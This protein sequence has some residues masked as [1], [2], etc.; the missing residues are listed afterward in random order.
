MIF[1]DLQSH[2]ST[3]PLVAALATGGAYWR[4]PFKTSDLL[5]RDYIIYTRHDLG[6]NDVRNQHRVQIVCFSN[7]MARLEALTEA[8]KS[9]LYG[10]HEV[11]S[12]NY[13]LIQFVNQTD[14]EDKLES[15]HYY[16]ILNYFFKE[17]P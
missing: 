5:S 14:G 11:G 7:S 10:V 1:E 12:T 9:S 13:Y 17:T 16:N 2:F 8:V 4:K 3:D 15:G 6:E